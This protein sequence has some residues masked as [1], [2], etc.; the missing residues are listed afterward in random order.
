MTM[1]MAA[2]TAVADMPSFV[3]RIEA[4]PSSAKTVKASSARVLET[5]TV[6]PGVK[7][8]VVG[9]SGT[10]LHYKRLIV[11]NM[12]Q[13]AINPEQLRGNAVRRAADET[14][15]LSEG[16]EAFTTNGWMPAGWGVSSKDGVNANPWYVL[17]GST[18]ELVGVDGKYLMLVN[19]QTEHCEEWLITPAFTPKEGM[20][21]SF[22]VNLDP[23]YMYSLD[24][25]NWNTMQYEGDKVEAYTLRVLV[26]EDNGDSWVTLKDYAKEQRFLDMSY[27]EAAAYGASLMKSETV[28]LAD[29]VGKQIKIAF[30]YDGTDGQ[31]CGIDNVHVG[32]PS[33]DASYD[34]PPYTLFFGVDKS[35]QSYNSS[36]AFLPVYTPLTW[37]NSSI[38]NPEDTEYTW[39][40][41]GPDNEEGVSSDESL[42]LTYHTDHT[43]DFSSR[44]NWYMTPTLT[45]S[46]SKAS[47]KSV[48]RYKYFQ[49][50]GEPVM[51]G[52]DTGTGQKYTFNFGLSTFDADSE[53]FDIF[54]TDDDD[55]SPIFGYGPKVDKYWTDYTFGGDNGEDEYAYL[56]AIIN[57]YT[58]TDSPLVIK[59]GWMPA[60][61][62]DIKPGH[63]FTFQVLPLDAEGVQTAPLATAT[64]KSEDIKV[65]EGG[66]MMDFSIL[67]FEFDQPLVISKENCD[68]Y[69]VRLGGMHGCANYFA[70]FMSAAD[71]PSHLALGWIDKAI[72]YNGEVRNSMTPVLNYT[73]MYQSFAIM[74]DAFYPWLESENS[75]ELDADGSGTLALDSYHYTDDLRVVN[76]PEWLDAQLVGGRYD[77]GRLVLKSSSAEPAEAAVT[78]VG[79]GV[80][81]QVTVKS[82]AVSS[83]GAV[84]A[85]SRE[86]EAIFTASGK[87][88]NAVSA[89][90][91]YVV[92]YRDGKVVKKIVK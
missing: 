38:G 1:A 56:D 71:N 85:G 77:K 17:P 23:V 25:I 29:Y 46:S 72:S 65:I 22:L 52:T 28:S 8:Q 91:V 16:F 74:L 49:A 2:G 45:A 92:K 37:T 76:A 7:E 36:I 14:S 26:S 11:N 81:K 27:S 57:Y 3:S 42:T 21:L 20:D 39:Q 48:T 41:M 55:A 44:N 88:V 51:V 31:L 83:V 67:S 79:Q 12:V 15:V 61:V 10:N 54:L 40:Y 75:I 47:P 73:G 30:E 70:P 4:G 87:R 68:A 19:Y 89:P 32:Y 63:E 9:L 78:I 43:S 50:G 84:D 59:G 5:R 35:M 33:L 6:A 66:G 58:A 90:G 60:M 69:T 82:P 64:C 53:G 80:A 86:V 62:S 13:N 18:T 24:N 34:F